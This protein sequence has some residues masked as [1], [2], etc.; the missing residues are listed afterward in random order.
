MRVAYPGGAV[1]LD[2]AA[3]AIDVAAWFNELPFWRLTARGVALEAQ[4]AASD[5]P[6]DEPGAVAL[7]PLAWLAGM[8]VVSVE[9]VKVPPV[10]AL[11]LS[12]AR[13]SPG[14]PV[15]DVRV[16]GALRTGG[17]LSEF[18]VTGT[19]A[20]TDDAGLAVN[21]AGSFSAAQA[22]PAQALQGRLRGVLAPVDSGLTVS[23]AHVAG[24]LGEA[25]G[26]GLYLPP[27]AGSVTVTGSWQQPV[28][29]LALT[30]AA[31]E[32]GDPLQA[33]MQ[34]TGSGRMDTVSGDFSA[35][36]SVGAKALPAFLNPAPLA[37]A[38]V[39][40]FDAR[41]SLSG[42][43]ETLLVPT[44]EISSPANELSASLETTLSGALVVA[45]DVQARQ[46]FV[47]L[48][49]VPE[50]A[51]SG[52]EATAPVETTGLSDDES[53]GGSAAPAPPAADAEADSEQAVMASAEPASSAPASSAPASSEPARVFDDTPLPL[54]WLADADV[55]VEV[56]A[57]TLLLQDAAFSNFTG[58]LLVENGALTL[59]RF[60]GSFGEGGFEGAL[61]VAP[62][63]QSGSYAAE[64]AFAMD[65]VQL[66]AFGLVPEEE[67]SGGR[68]H[69]R[70]DLAAVGASPREL[71]AS[72]GGELLLLVDEATLADDLIELAG[73]DFIMETINTLNPFYRED[74]STELECALVRFEAED[75]KLR[76]RNE[77]V[78]ETTK[79]EIIGNGSVDLGE[80]SLDITL[81]PSAKA[82]VGIN[83]GSLVKFLKVGGTL[84]EPAPA[85]D[86]VGVLAT[87]ATVGAAVSTGGLSLLAEGL[88]KRALNAGSVCDKFRSDPK[89]EGSQ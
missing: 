44:L 26:T 7:P 24:R 15:M 82:G 77:L 74:P 60:S 28:V 83:A 37:H 12:L 23:L 25:S 88:A 35:D 32:A 58:Q 56:Q 21:V 76:T 59:E 57:E 84:A 43:P 8:Q 17:D 10:E 67:L 62:A 79:M 81:S 53:L 19:L 47:P 49:T 73:S 41:V 63:A 69:A 86:A 46:L 5:A 31:D 52:T 9:D 39:L 87:G 54:D 42:T 80:E 13:V 30:L 1:Q 38:H 18:A 66:A 65:D 45:A 50:A 14:E 75:G 3:G 72:L 70:A 64:L 33:S 11:A 78:V 36:L 71:A 27:A 16:S 2:S 22:P 4:R 34:V 89:E 85:V 55:R 40:P 51:V 29:E 48:T 6:A 68:M 61:R 20:Q